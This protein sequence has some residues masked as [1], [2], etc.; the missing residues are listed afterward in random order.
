MANSKQISF[1][2]LLK[3]GHLITQVGISDAFR[4]DQITFQ[5]DESGNLSINDLSFVHGSIF[6]CSALAVDCGLSYFFQCFDSATITI[7]DLDQLE[8]GDGISVYQIS[9]GEI[10][11]IKF[12]DPQ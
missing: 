9:D 8:W 2:G 12:N 6:T 11:E 10:D 7:T 4:T 3:K 5:I 1:N